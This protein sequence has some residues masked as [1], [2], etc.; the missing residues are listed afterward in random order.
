MRLQFYETTIVETAPDAEIDLSTIDKP[1]SLDVLTSRIFGEELDY[2]PLL[3]GA[4]RTWRVDSLEDAVRVVTLLVSESTVWATQIPDSWFVSELWSAND[5]PG[6][7]P[8]HAARL[9]A[10]YVVVTPLIPVESSPLIKVSLGEIVV[11]GGSSVALALFLGHPVLLAIGVFGL[12][13]LRVSGA[14]WEGARPEVSLFGR[15]LAHDLLNLLRVR[16]GIPLREGTAQESAA[17]DYRQTADQRAESVRTGEV[18]EGREDVIGGA[19]R[20][21]EQ[22]D[23]QAERA[24]YRSQP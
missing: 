15:D 24:D 19:R 9:F 18:E 22:E 23:E 6:Q 10:E 17:A 4:D 12:I 20:A 14:A 21:S 5:K 3:E 1:F 16:L 2:R 13:T 8:P 7:R 11:S